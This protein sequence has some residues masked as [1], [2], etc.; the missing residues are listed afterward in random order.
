MKLA[1]ID[2]EQSFAP[3]L[4]IEHLTKRK[5]TFLFYGLVWKS[6]QISI[7]TQASLIFTIPFSLPRAKTEICQAEQL[8]NYQ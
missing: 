5:K 3:F 4:T 7:S 1:Q 6:P 8:S 2:G